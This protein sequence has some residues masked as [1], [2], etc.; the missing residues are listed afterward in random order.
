MKV[1]NT[2]RRAQ[3]FRVEDIVGWDFN[4]SWCWCREAVVAAKFDVKYIWYMGDLRVLPIWLN[5]RQLYNELSCVSTGVLSIILHFS[6]Q[7]QS[8]FNRMPSIPPSSLEQCFLHGLPFHLVAI[9]K[10]CITHTTG[11]PS[12]AL[13][14]YALHTL[15]IYIALRTLHINLHIYFAYRLRWRPINSL[16]LSHS[17]SLY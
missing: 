12:L 15:L 8:L 11:W 14:L 3:S 2:S 16:S 4:C 17:I 13:C 7:S 10:L 5:I 1:K 6:S 9:C